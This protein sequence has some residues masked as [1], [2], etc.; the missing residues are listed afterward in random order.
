MADTRASALNVLPAPVDSDRIVGVRVSNSDVGL[1]TISNLRTS[2]TSGL[3]TTSG[4]NNFTGG[5]T[6]TSAVNLS[7][8][9][10]TSLLSNP[11]G[12][13][14]IVGNN[15]DDFGHFTLSSLRTFLNSGLPTT[16]G[17]NNFTGSNT[18]TN[19]I[20]LSNG[21]TTALL[22][23]P[24]DTSTIIGSSGSSFGHFTVSNLRTV[25]T[26]GLVSDTG[27]ET[28]AGIKTF[29]NDIIAGDDIV[30]GNARVFGGTGSL[31][32]KLNFVNDSGQPVG[33][34][35]TVEGGTATTGTGRRNIDIG[36]VNT[37]N[38]GDLNSLR[39]YES[40]LELATGN[41]VLPN[42]G[43]ITF[44]LAATT[45]ATGSSSTSKTLD[46]YEEGTWTPRPTVAGSTNGSIESSEPA[47]YTKIGNLVTCKF[48]ISYNTSTSTSSQLVSD[49][50]FSSSQSQGAG[51]YSYNGAY[52]GISINNTGVLLYRDPDGGF[53]SASDL[54]GV[55]FVR[56]SIT[57]TTIA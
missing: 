28:I 37:S 10:N 21:I 49:L 19:A 13:T 31:S 6:F 34:I 3:P 20:N 7:N 50:P 41:V 5:N 4:S 54:S 30:I 33:Q 2:L 39:L 45:T 32:N 22:P 57:Y 43:G 16:S 23:A 36:L 44:G 56:H 27:N 8:G 46:D 53:L 15:G 11:T 48:T 18:F 38:T 35:E 14:T 47:V 51:A 42:N 1:F 24:S 25:L 12:S 29:S 9:I 52:G 26:D 17:S 55:I 40:G